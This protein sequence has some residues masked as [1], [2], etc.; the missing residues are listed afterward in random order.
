M[1]T[2]TSSGLL[3]RPSRR[4]KQF[5]RASTALAPLALA[6]LAQ[7]PAHLQLWEGLGQVSLG[8][9][10]GGGGVADVEGVP[11]GCS[12]IAKRRRSRRRAVIARAA[13]GSTL[14][15]LRGLG[16]SSDL[17]EGVPIEIAL[18]VSRHYLKERAR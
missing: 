9:E 17:S 6:S 3:G 5:A 10:E 14:C 11:R 12:A 7:Q 18:E 16:G 13:T 1:P 4:V 15:E 2:G 8:P